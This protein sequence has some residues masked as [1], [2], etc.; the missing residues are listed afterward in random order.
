MADDRNPW[1]QPPQPPPGA[2]APEPRR[3]GVALAAIVALAVFAGLGLWLSS[4]AE[5]EASLRQAIAAVA[6]GLPAAPQPVRYAAA[7]PAPAQ[8]KAAYDHVRTVYADGGP[9]ALVKASAACAKGLSREPRQLDRCLAFDMYAADI[10]PAGGGDEAAAWFHD[11]DRALALARSALPA[12]ADAAD[13]I[14]Q[15]RALTMAVLPK[16]RIE[17]VRAAPARLQK[18]RRVAARRARPPR[19]AR[20]VK[21]TAPVRLWSSPYCLGAKSEADRIVCSDPGLAEQDRKMREA[22]G[23]ATASSADPDALTQ[24][25]ANWRAA[26]DAAKDRQTL[27]RLYR[28]RLQDLDPGT[29]PH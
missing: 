19:R 3:S 14:G 1:A 22:Y 6:P 28:E 4:R 8:V 11:P 29:P 20:L 5:P 13:R 18:A 7:D 12:G 17:R 21:A 16:P 24:E 15:V 25:Q 9:D 23:R 26:R 2:S 10:L 27:G